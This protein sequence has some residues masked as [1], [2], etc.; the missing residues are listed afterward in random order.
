MTA[1]Y[2]LDSSV[3]ITLLRNQPRDIYP[4]VWDR[5]YAVLRSGEA[6]VPREAVEE[7]SRGTD[8]LAGWVRETGAVF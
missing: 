8:D 7:L 3:L 1:K 4:T 5:L 6:V 2:V